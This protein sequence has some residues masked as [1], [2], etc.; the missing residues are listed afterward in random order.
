M[1]INGL[2]LDGFRGIYADVPLSHPLAL[3]AGENNSGKSAI[4][5][6]LRLVTAPYHDY[7]SRPQVRI[8]DFPH[9]G[10]GL[11]TADQI[12]ISVLLTGLD[13]SERGRM[14]TCLTPGRGPGTARLTL[15]ARLNDADRV[16]T[17]FSGGDFGNTDVE[18]FA[19]TAIK[20]V[21]LP[22]LRDAT[23]DLRPGYAN[24]LAELVSA[25]APVAGGDRTALEQIIDKANTDLAA[26][27]AVVDATDAIAKS[28]G[29]L[30][31]SSSFT[32]L[33]DLQ[34]SPARYERIVSSLRALMG[35]LVPLEL[36]ENGLGYNNLLYMAV[37]LSVL[38]NADEAPLQVLLVEEPEAHL[39]PQLQA[40]LMEYLE[41]QA[42]DET[43]VVL[44]THS[45]QLA[46][47]ARV[48]RLTV[49]APSETGDRTARHLGSIGLRPDQ[50]SHLRRF[51]DVTKS[52]LLFSKGVILVEGIAEQ[53]LMPEIS[54]RLG[55]S[56]TQHGIS[57]VNVSGLAF[58]P[59][60]ALF[61]PN[62]LPLRCSVVTD[63]DPAIESGDY[64]VDELE[65]SS[66]AAAIVARQTDQVRP[67][68]ATRTLEWDLA[69][70]GDGA[71]RGALLDALARVHPR[72][73][74][75]LNELDTTPQAW[76][77]AFLDAIRK[78]KGDFSLELAQTLADDS[79][80]FEIPEYLEQAVAWV[81]ESTDVSAIGLAG[82][83]DSSEQASHGHTEA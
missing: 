72:K 22:A 21:Y 10:T 8:E 79:W 60:T 39:H 40:L 34:F 77:D 69:Y 20:N 28:L 45:P 68:V 78:S 81:A 59:F 82:V 27:P 32:Q 3:V 29:G 66:T 52:S 16:V 75:R 57:V 49:M 38:Q 17:W 9:D 83:A 11:R 43:Q 2:E 26:I 23:R 14:A 30:T 53:L 63:G 46:S 76:A 37:L 18:S 48:E 1:Y 73:A 35:R 24:R 55:V 80:E 71:N 36:D 62:G 4:I 58:D 31:G 42:G 61:T 56:L 74:A 5:D 33:S 44:T 13:L 7:R 47:T 64:V 67:H 15:H 6:A 54:R 70:A 12:A 50:L 65:I 19:K 41:L 51:L 25:F